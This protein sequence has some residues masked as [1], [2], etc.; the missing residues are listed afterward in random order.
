MSPDGAWIIPDWPA[1]AG[2]RAAVSTRQGPGVST[3]PW[4]RFNLGA[5]CGDVPEAVAANRTAVRSALG[6]GRDPRWLQQV[7]GVDVA[8]VDRLADAQ[9]PRADAAV[10]DQA[11]QPLAILTADC[12][13]VLFCT[14]DGQSVAAAHAGWRG[15][16]AG[17]LEATVNALKVPPAQ[18]MAWLGPCIGKASYEVGGEVRDAFMAL[19]VDAGEGFEPTRP[20]HWLCD[21]AWLA[22]RRLQVAGVPAIYGGG[23]DTRTDDRFYSYRRDGAQSGRFASLIWR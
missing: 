3:G 15:L 1:P 19:D 23:F 12:L 10:T 5:R 22:R 13:P 16:Q 11:D 7:H 17:V 2:V 18:V 6:L 20:G 8:D 21:L 14:A 4:G 9:E